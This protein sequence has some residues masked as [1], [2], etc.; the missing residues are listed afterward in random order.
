MFLNPW[1]SGQQ[2][3]GSIPGTNNSSLPGSHGSNCQPDS[4][5]GN[6]A[7]SVALVNSSSS[8]SILNGP[9]HKGPPPPPPP[10]HQRN[11][12]LSTSNSSTT[13]T[14][15][16]SQNNSNTSSMN[17]SISGT[18]CVTFSNEVQQF[19]DNNSVYSCS[20]HGEPDPL[21]VNGVTGVGVLQSENHYMLTSDLRYDNGDRNQEGSL[22]GIGM[23]NSLF[24]LSEEQNNHL[25]TVCCLER[26]KFCIIYNLLKLFDMK[27]VI[28][29]QQFFGI[30]FRVVV[31][32]KNLIDKNLLGC[33]YLIGIFIGNI[34]IKKCHDVPI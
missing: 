15:K 14:S 24:P 3:N 23:A 6:S 2:Q 4:G 33:K 19:S 28:F 18:T 34:S 20:S 26:I 12:I 9:S 7:T 27:V 17:G 25:Q 29:H 5:I 22:A 11:G 1:Y 21:L 16:P 13:S 31:K 30:I 32:R 8:S 10:P